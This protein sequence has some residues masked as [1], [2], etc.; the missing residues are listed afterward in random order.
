MLAK[1][2]VDQIDHLLRE[3]GLSQRAIARRLGVARGTIAAIASGRRGLHGRESETN[4]ADTLAPLAPAERCRRC[5]HR[6]YLPC[7][8]CRNRDYRARHR[9][10]SPI[11][12][13]VSARRRRAGGVES[14]GAHLESQEADRRRPIVRCGPAAPSGSY[15]VAVEPASSAVY[16]A[17]GR[18]RCSSVLPREPAGRES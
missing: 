6:V 1:S 14:A 8:V 16:P 18:H 15:S 2:L 9:A 4:D 12:T 11:A 13:G 10:G 5:G 17:D 7:L 3:G